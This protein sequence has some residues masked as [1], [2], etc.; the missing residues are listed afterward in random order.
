MRLEPH[1]TSM[2]FTGQSSP[3]LGERPKRTFTINKSPSGGMEKSKQWERGERRG[4]EPEA[5]QE[6]KAAPSV[7]ARKFSAAPA[8]GGFNSLKIVVNRARN[9]VCDEMSVGLT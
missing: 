9:L 4:S 8:V 5:D 7:S 2:P 3:S 6:L 1:Q